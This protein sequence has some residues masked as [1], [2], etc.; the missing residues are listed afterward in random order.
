[1]KTQIRNS[2]SAIILMVVTLLAGNGLYAQPGQG[3]RG[4]Q[5]GGQQG[6]PAVPDTQQIKEMVSTLAG[7][8][9]LTE[10]QEATVLKYYTEHFKQVKAKTSGNARPGREEM[11]ALQTDLE[12]KVKA[13]LTKE[14]QTKYAAYLEKQAARRGGPQRR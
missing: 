8:I 9:S 11:Q 6:P 4:G 5:Q 12:S 1:M 7:E 10:T 13:V 3:Q 2:A 14:Q